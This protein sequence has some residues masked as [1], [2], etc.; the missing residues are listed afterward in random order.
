MGMTDPVADLLTRVRNAMKAGHRKVSI[1]ASIFKTDVLKVLKVE[2]FISDFEVKKDKKQGMIIVRLKYTSDK[3][4]VISKIKRIS[5]PGLR[6]YVNKNKIPKVLNGLGIAVLST[7]KGVV[8][9]DKA[10]ELGV[11]GEVIC[12]V[13]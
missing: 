12:T 1:P 6:V 10:E 3:R 11:G 2:G 5:K 7:S 9:G 13:Y 4:G 8:T